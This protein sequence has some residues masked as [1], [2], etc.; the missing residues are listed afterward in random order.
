MRILALATVLSVIACASSGPPRGALAEDAPK[1]DTP[2]VARVQC[3][4]GRG[5]CD[6]D[7]GNGCE[8]DLSTDADNCRACGHACTAGNAGAAMCIDGRCAQSARGR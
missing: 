7:P 2:A 8:A 3:P 5:D 4:E 1:A 6:G